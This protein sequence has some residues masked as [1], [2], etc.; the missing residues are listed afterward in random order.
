M[1]SKI[2]KRLFKDRR[3]KVTLSATLEYVLLI[4][5]I[6]CSVVEAIL[7]KYVLLESVKCDFEKSLTSI[8]SKICFKLNSGESGKYNI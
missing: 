5:R 3:E 7:L 8:I 6:Y 2:A 4:H 1:F